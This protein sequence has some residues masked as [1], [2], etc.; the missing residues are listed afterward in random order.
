MESFLAF[1]Q[2]LCNTDLV[3]ACCNIYNIS[4]LGDVITL[5][6][7]KHKLGIAD[8]IGSFDEENIDDVDNDDGGDDDVNDDGGDDAGDSNKVFFTAHFAL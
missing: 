5:S 4:I 6:L 7:Q 1:Y 2:K 8:L 3:Q